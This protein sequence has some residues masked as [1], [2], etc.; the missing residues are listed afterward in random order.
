MKVFALVLITFILAAIFV[1]GAW[2]WVRIIAGMVAA[3]RRD[4][5]CNDLQPKSGVKLKT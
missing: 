1:T 3:W 4:A 5:S 2:A